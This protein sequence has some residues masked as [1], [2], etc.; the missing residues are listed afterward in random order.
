MLPLA[1][2]VRRTIRRYDLIPAGTRVLVALSGGPDSVALL[3]LLQ[4][5]SARDGYEVVGAAHLHHG[6]RG[7][8]ADE[9][10]AFCRR[11]A[12]ERSLPID[13]EAADVG[14]LARKS[15]TS[16]EHAA[17]DAR[18][19]FF[20]RAAGRMG[21]GRVAVGHTRDDQAETFLLRLLRGAG[22]RGLG[23]I[24]PRAGAIVRPL[25]ACR[26]EELRAFLAAQGI[27]FRE[28]ATNA[29]VS[30]LRNR[31]RHELVPFLRDR[32][33]PR[34]VQVL[35]RDAAIARED[36]AF[37]G[38]A[39]RAVAARLTV[40]M[41]AG[42]GIPAAALATEDPAIARRVA[43]EAQQAVSG[44]RFIG[45][46]AVE[47]L[48]EF[49]ASG[50]PGPLDLP[51]HRVER[52]GALVVLSPAGPRRGRGERT[53]AC[54][55]AYT[56]SIPGQ[57]T[58]PESA[59]VVS[60]EPGVVPSGTPTPAPWPLAGRGDTAVIDAAA[61]EGPLV[62]RSRRPGD[63]FRPLGLQ[64]HKKLQDFF[65]DRRIPRARRD[66]VPLVVDRRGLIVWVAGHAVAEEA[67][68]TGR[69]AAVVVLRMKTPGDLE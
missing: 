52:R 23:G 68:V 39:A 45:F 60:A 47:A 67:K 28:D 3:T 8:E 21:A 12:L 51:G 33:S 30:I 40:R 50:E 1:E 15:R 65:V 4:L 61:I 31:V 69:T 9:D 53:P 2:R 34:V 26:R 10:E 35:D 7:R 59:C 22:P 17:H 54:A 63:R 41:P 57:V 19:A 55:F 32:F 13:V 20:A 62:V 56:L 42:M 36:A 38:D 43:R 37:L 48:L 14:R 27:E 29:D 64:G 49:A 66:R 16:I 46:D 58:V 6:L 44:G 18:Y 5:L 11:L 25:L 24:H